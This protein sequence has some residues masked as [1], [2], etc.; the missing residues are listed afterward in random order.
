MIFKEKGQVSVE[1][2]IMVS[3]ITFL[4]ISILGVAFFYVGGV[5]DKIKFDQVQNFASK[6]ISSSEKTF[7]SGEPSK[8]VINAYLPAGVESAGIINNSLVFNVS[9]SSGLTII[10]FKSNVPIQ[11]SLSSG[12]GLKR[13]TIEAKTDRVELAEG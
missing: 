8:V 9:S 10:S 1:Y 6:I 3:F 13:I 12:Q 11:G 4:I 7:Y 5:S 2:L